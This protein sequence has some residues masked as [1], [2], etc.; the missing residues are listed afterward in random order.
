[1]NITTSNRFVLA[2]GLVLQQAPTVCSRMIMLQVPKRTSIAWPTTCQKKKAPLSSLK[3]VLGVVLQTLLNTKTGALERSTTTLLFTAVVRM[4]R[5]CSTSGFLSRALMMI[6][7]LI[8]PRCCSQ[9]RINSHKWPETLGQE[10]LTLTN[11]LKLPEH[12][13]RNLLGFGGV[14]RPPDLIIQDELHLLTGPLGTIAGLVETAIETA[15]DSVDH[16]P[17]Y[18]AATAT[19]RGAERDAMLMFGRRMN[20]FPPPVETAADN[21]FAKLDSN[22]NEGRTH[23]AIMG[24]PG[25]SRT[26]FSQPTASFLQRLKQ[27]RVENPHVPD[28]VFDPYF[29]LVAYFNSLRELGS[30]QTMLP[31]RV[32]REFIGADMPLLAVW[33]RERFLRLKN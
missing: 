25:A 28:A 30:A 27:L 8:H 21:F 20:I 2:C 15:W 10:A 6:F 4:N 17:K 24:P 23:I 3:Y 33:K 14:S 13:T 5:A 26:M 9:R 22:P 11:C 12:T 19:I 7:T 18:V 31:D 16:R 32:A 1:M 29:T